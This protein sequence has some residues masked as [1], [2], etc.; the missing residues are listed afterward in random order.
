MGT[1]VFFEKDEDPP[2]IEPV[3]DKDIPEHFRYA[4]KTHKVLNLCRIFVEPKD[5][6]N[7]VDVDD[8]PEIPEESAFPLPTSAQ[9]TFSYEEALNILPKDIGKKK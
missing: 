4:N 1:H 3:F 5:K 6:V 9:T 8:I 2:S 7:E